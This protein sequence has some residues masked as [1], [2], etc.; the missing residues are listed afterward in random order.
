[1]S[2]GKTSLCL[3]GALFTVAILNSF[4]TVAPGHERAFAVE[5]GLLQ[6]AACACG[7]LA[8][9]LRTSLKSHSIHQ[10]RRLA[11]TYAAFATVLGV[12]LLLASV[13]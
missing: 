2:L 13:G 1:M 11:W 10:S 9:L 5:E 12:A 7:A 3:S 6:F 4:V 8:L